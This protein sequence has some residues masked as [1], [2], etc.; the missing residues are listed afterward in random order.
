M[1][2]FNQITKPALYLFTLILSVAILCAQGVRL[3][4]HS[5]A[6]EH[7]H[8]LQQHSHNS[9]TAAETPIK[10]SQALHSHQSKIH[11]VSDISHSDHH[12]EMIS[13]LDASPDGF[14]TKVNSNLLI[15]A[16]LSSLFTLLLVNFYQKILLRYR[17]ETVIFPRRFL[18][19]PPLRAPPL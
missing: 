2:I 4:I 6:Q 14:L 18:F 8:E 19:S 11:P 13:E 7:N 15:L 12:D 9:H 5:L 3:H 16:L 10:N 17:E 1:I